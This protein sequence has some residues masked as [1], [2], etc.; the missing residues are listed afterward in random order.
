MKKLITTMALLCFPFGAYAQDQEVWACQQDEAAGLFWENNRWVTQRVIAQTLLITIPTAP[1]SRTEVSDNR[2]N[3]TFKT[4]DNSIFGMFCRTNSFD[5]MSCISDA[6]YQMFL[7]DRATGR[8]GYASLFGAL[9]S[10]DR[11]DT[12]ASHIYNCTKF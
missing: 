10:D 2:S 6:G 5:D 7:F 3:G 12:V 4:G 11:R 9:M 8:L 1:P